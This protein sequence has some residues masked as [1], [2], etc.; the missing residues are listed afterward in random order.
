MYA[1]VC[2]EK[3]IVNNIKKYLTDNTVCGCACGKIFVR[4]V[5]G[6]EIAL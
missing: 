2:G 6:P 3:K 1:L 4:T 5:G